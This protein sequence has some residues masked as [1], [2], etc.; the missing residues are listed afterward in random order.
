MPLCDLIVAM[1]LHKLG[2]VRGLQ[3]TDEIANS[4]DSRHH[5]HAHFFTHLI[6]SIQLH[7]LKDRVLGKHCTMAEKQWSISIPPLSLT[8]TQNKGKLCVC[9][10][11]GTACLLYYCEQSRQH[12]SL[13]F[14]LISILSDKPPSVTLCTLHPQ[15]I[16]STLPKTQWGSNSAPLFA[17]TSLPLFAPLPW[18][19]RC[20]L[21]GMEACLDRNARGEEGRG[22]TTEGGSKCVGGGVGVLRE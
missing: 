10:Q 21:V 7:R 9:E 8:H 13:P 16:P 6:C 19:G 1:L 18:P 11:N 17:P 22:P 15:H 5:T 4:C 20:W 3:C 2:S 12:N 14:I